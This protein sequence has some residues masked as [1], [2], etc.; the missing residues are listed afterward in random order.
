LYV[1]FINTGFWPSDSKLSIRQARE[2]AAMGLTFA[3]DRL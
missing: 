2:L 3:K 1:S